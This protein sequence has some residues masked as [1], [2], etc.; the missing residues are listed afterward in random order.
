MRLTNS[1]CKLYFIWAETPSPRYFV[2][3][4]I[5]PFQP[6][7]LVSLW[8]VCVVLM[9]I[10]QV[11]EKKSPSE[12]FFVVF[13]FP[14]S[15]L[16]LN[17]IMWW[18][19]S[20]STHFNCWRFSDCVCVCLLSKSPSVLFLFHGTIYSL[21]LHSKI[22]GI[23][24]CSSEVPAGI[25]SRTSWHLLFSTWELILTRSLVTFFP[26]I[27]KEKK[28]VLVGHIMVHAW[29]GYRWILQ[30]WLMRRSGY[31][32]IEKLTGGLIPASCIFCVN[33]WMWLLVEKYFEWFASC[34]KCYINAVLVHLFSVRHFSSYSN[35]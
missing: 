29:G 21:D 20:S 11:L 32:L 25:Y 24:S 34:G 27:Y 3:I 10:T 26:S 2:A 28:K 15:L 1:D 4:I 12:P 8:F 9:M 35:F 31:F 14:L 7:T 19:P 13:F 33:E 5:I 16:L 18:R 30:L 6:W 22:P 17:F 23:I